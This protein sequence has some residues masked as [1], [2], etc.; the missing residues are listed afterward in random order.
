MANLVVEEAFTATVDLLTEVCAAPECGL[1]LGL[2]TDHV[3]VVADV[4]AG[5]PAVLVWHLTC[6]PAALR[7][8]HSA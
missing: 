1:V 3:G 2:S 8:A 4:D 5:T 7:R 6:A